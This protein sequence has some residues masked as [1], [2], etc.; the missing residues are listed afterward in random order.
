[1][2]KPMRRVRRF[3]K[4]RSKGK[5]TSYG[6]G[7][8]RFAFVTS[9]DDDA[10]D[11]IFFGGRGMSKGNL[12]HHSLPQSEAISAKYTEFRFYGIYPSLISPEIW[13]E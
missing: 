10:V 2:Q 3:F 5:G 6:K 12:F 8:H 7:A 9:Y 13:V 11:Q 4:R 1:M